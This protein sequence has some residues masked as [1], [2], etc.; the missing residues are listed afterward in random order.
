MVVANTSAYARFVWTQQVFAKNVNWNNELYSAL[1]A[2]HFGEDI[3]CET[4]M[5]G[6]CTP[7]A[8]TACSASVS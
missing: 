4:W 1:V 8:A 5:H 3:W 6:T 2:E 7:S